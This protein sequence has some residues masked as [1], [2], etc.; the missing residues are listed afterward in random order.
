M[1]AP[2]GVDC[3]DSHVGIIYCKCAYTK[4]STVVLGHSL[5][6]S[7]ARWPQSELGDSP[8]TIDSL[9]APERDVLPRNAVIAI[10]APTGRKGYVKNFNGVCRY[11]KVEGV[12]NLDRSRGRIYMH[13]DAASRKSG[14]RTAYGR[15]RASFS[16]RSL[17]GKSVPR[18]KGE[19]YLILLKCGSVNL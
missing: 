11:L 14:H 18:K 13:D 8:N 4:R 12:W 16:P 17:C 15:G 2:Y 19:K 1:H 7:D 10:D 9:R 6:Q 3:C 5:S